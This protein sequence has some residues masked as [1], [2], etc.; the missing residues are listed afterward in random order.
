MTGNSPNLKGHRERENEMRAYDGLPR[1]EPRVLR[2]R[3]RSPGQNI[4]KPYGRA[5]ARKHSAAC[6]PTIRMCN[7][8]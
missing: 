5:A 1:K 4:G 7:K 2:T 8:S 3:I 6:I